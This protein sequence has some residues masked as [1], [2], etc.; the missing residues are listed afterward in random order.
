MGRK[1][2][3][4]WN[5]SA[6]RLPLVFSVLAASCLAS[7]QGIMPWPENPQYWAYKGEPVLLL[8][9]SKTDHI[10]LLD[11]LREHL[12]EIQAEGGNY[13]RC[14]MSQRESAALKPH[15]LRADGK[16]DLDAWNEDYWRRFVDCLKWCEERGI[17]VQIELWDRFDYSQE[18]WRDSPWR[19][20]NNI[21]YTSEE[22]GL[23]DAYPAPAYRD[24]QP[25]FHT[26][27]GLDR[28]DARY[29]RIRGCQ[30]A[31]A[32]KMLSYSL[33]YDHVLYCIGNESSAPDEWGIYW[34]KFIKEKAKE[35]GV[36]VYVTQMYDSCR[37]EPVV[38]RHDVYD[39][40]EGSKIIGPRHRDWAYKGEGQ[41]NKIRETH[42]AMTVA[43]R[44]INAVKIISVIDEDLDHY[45]QRKF[46]RG[47]F[48][49]MA[50]I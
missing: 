34:A 13:V 14:T 38:N 31:F 44:P 45:S 30:E 17:I 6:W 20:A 9:G 50:A 18:Q 25:F 2:V 22:T 15:L 19:P 11:D 46:W 28:Y 7:A 42:A 29:D 35:R 47:L 1:S 3:V 5:P 27:P 26:L 12:D 33:E 40:V 49:G 10:F 24:K 21:N 16:F 23:A 8:G 32:A 43:P 48:A 36:A 37:L 39:F 4:S 41:W